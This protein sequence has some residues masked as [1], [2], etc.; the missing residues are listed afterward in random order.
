[1]LDLYIMG[2]RIREAREKLGY[3]REQLAEMAHISP[4]F[5]YDIEAGRKGVSIETLKYICE[6]LEVTADH[7]LDINHQDPEQVE[8]SV[9]HALIERCPPGYRHGLYQIILAYIEALTNPPSNK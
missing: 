6:S 5:Y 4:R 7:L 1:M 2:S 8:Y 3:T 9:F